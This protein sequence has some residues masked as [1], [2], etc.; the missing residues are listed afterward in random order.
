MSESSA[1]IPRPQREPSA[2]APAESHSSGE[3]EAF[4]LLTPFRELQLVELH[5]Q[6]DP[7]ALGVL[8]RSYQRRIYSVCYRMIR[9]PEEARDLTQ[10][11]MV[12]IMEG[13]PSFDARAR[14]STWVI[15]VTMNLCI[16]YLRKRKVRRQSSL[17]AV[18]DS[19]TGSAVV[20]RRLTGEGEPQPG[21]RVEQ[22]ESRE[23]VIRALEQIDPQMRAVLVL[24][25]MHDLD[26]QQIAEVIESPVGTVKSRLFRARAAL[27]DAIEELEAGACRSETGI[28][29]G[30]K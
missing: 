1:P 5:Q 15:R 6:G 30:D 20:G 21:D 23:T 9:D 17:D 16:S 26:Y 3:E 7:D 28:G 11:A 24:R 19:D 14:L 22:Q 12:R 18:L 29:D 25:D 13:L 4:P 8:L 2:G 27:R 10:E